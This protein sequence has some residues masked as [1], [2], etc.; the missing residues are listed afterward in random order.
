MLRKLDMEWYHLA[1]PTGTQSPDRNARTRCQH[2]HVRPLPLWSGFLPNYIAAE[3][4]PSRAF[5]A[6]FTLQ[7]I[8]H[9]LRGSPPDGEFNNIASMFHASQVCGERFRARRRWLDIQPN[10]TPN[11]IPK[12]QVDGSGTGVIPREILS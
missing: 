6:A 11:P 3:Q 5:E 4:L 1:D 8:D 9:P 10:N 2:I 7:L 12:A